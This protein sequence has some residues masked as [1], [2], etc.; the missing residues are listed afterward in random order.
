MGFYHD[1]FVDI[2]FWE[3]IRSIV[4][5][6]PRLQKAIRLSKTEMPTNKGKMS[7]Y[8]RYLLTYPGIYDCHLL[9]I[10]WIGSQYIYHMYA[11]SLKREGI[12]IN[13]TLIIT[14][15]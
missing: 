1:V 15:I 2:L 5:T 14:N 10:L 4:L 9:Y 3:K 12:Y 13:T 11:A 8:A 7:T 6:L